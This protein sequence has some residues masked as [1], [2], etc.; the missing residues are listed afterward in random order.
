MK[1]L[2]ILPFDMSAVT[3]T[4][5]AVALVKTMW[6]LMVGEIPGWCVRFKPLGI[7]AAQLVVERVD[8]GTTPLWVVELPPALLGAMDSQPQFGWLMLKAPTAESAVAVIRFIL[9]PIA[10]PHLADLRV[11]PLSHEDLACIDRNAQPTIPS[12]C[13]AVVGDEGQ[14]S[15]QHSDRPA[16]SDPPKPLR[17]ESR[18]RHRF[19]YP[20]SGQKAGRT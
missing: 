2:T 1:P 3:D 17:S 19:H 8:A 18:P 15:G 20:R 16:S 11:R 4:L 10:D 9:E 12:P 6:A 13:N 14:R 5:A 7:Q